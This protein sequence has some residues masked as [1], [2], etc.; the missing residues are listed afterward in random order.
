LKELAVM[1]SLL[2]WLQGLLTDPE[3]RAAFF[4]DPDSFMGTAGFDHLSATDL[5]DALILVSDNEP[6]SYDDRFSDV[7]GSGFSPGT[8][9]VLAGDS[10]SD[11]LS[12]YLATSYPTEANG[13][14]SFTDHADNDP[15]VHAAND[16]PPGVEPG[17]DHPA[18][19]V[20]GA[21]VADP[22]FGAGFSGEPHPGLESDFA[23]GGHDDSSLYPSGVT[24]PSQLEHYEDDAVVAHNGPGYEPMF[25]D[26]LK[27]D[28]DHIDHSEH[29]AHHPPL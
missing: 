15:L 2:T 11:Y 10:P 25:G 16:G 23:A 24:G 13:F 3:A 14:E 20:H 18:M 29:E 8:V 5:H 6:V 12:N 7:V 19:S 22:G 17:A 27:T 26:D 28:P 1:I 21:D 4:S 9:D